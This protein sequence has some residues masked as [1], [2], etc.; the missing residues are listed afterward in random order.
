MTVRSL[1]IQPLITTATATATLAIAGLSVVGLSSFG[2]V[3]SAPAITRPAEASVVHVA[4]A[5]PLAAS[6][7]RHH[8]S[9]GDANSDNSR[10]NRPQEEPP[11]FTPG[12]G[13]G[14]AGGGE[15]DGEGGGGYFGT[16][17]G[18]GGM[19]SSGSGGYDPADPNF[20]TD[21]RTKMETRGCGTAGAQCGAQPGAANHQGH[22]KPK[23]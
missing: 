8:D 11:L 5:T 6:P 13:G 17:S 2:H 12:S 22:R 20:K 15:G 10:G 9:A 16:E 18:D 19:F 1:T 21:G 23:N 3:T 7:S 4:M 14:A